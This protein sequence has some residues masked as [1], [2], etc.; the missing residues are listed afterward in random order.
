MALKRLLLSFLLF[1]PTLCAR[2]ESHPVIE[3]LRATF[4]SLAMRSKA[5]FAAHETLAGQRPVVGLRAHFGAD[6][7]GGL[8]VTFPR[9]YDGLLLAE[10]G[11]QRIVLRAIGASGAPA[12]PASGMLVYGRPYQSVDVVHVPYGG[13][14]EE[15]LLLRDERAPLVFEYEIVAT[16]GIGSVA[17]DDGG[18]RFVREGESRGAHQQ[19]LRIERPWLI[20]ANGTK[21]ETQARWSLVGE[22]AM[23]DAIRLTIDPR[24]LVFPI[25]VDPSFSATGGLAELRD[26]H[27]ATLLPDGNVLIAGGNNINIGPVESS[28]LYDPSTGIV[29]PA[30][31]L[32]FP[33]RDHSATLLRN[34]RVLVAGG[35]V[36]A[37]STATAELYDPARGTFSLTG[38][39]A[40]SR[41]RASAT[42][43]PSGEVLIVGG[44][45]GSGYAS[46]AELYD[47]VSGTFRLTGSPL[48]ERDSA[49]A[50]LLQDGRV[51]V[52]GGTWSVMTAEIYDPATGE[53]TAS[54]DL[55]TRRRRATATLLP[56]GKVLVVGGT[57]G[58]P[59]MTAELFDPA[60]GTFEETGSM[61]W[62]RFDHTATL[63][64]NG[65]VLITGGDDYNDELAT[66]E[67][68]DPATETFS[69]AD[70]L[71]SGQRTVHAAVLLQS[72]KVLLAGGRSGSFA[73]VASNELYD[74]S[75]PSSTAIASSVAPRDAATGTIL[76]NGNVLIAGGTNGTALGSAE[77]YNAATGT[78]ASTGGLAAVRAHHTA[79]LLLNGKVLVAGGE[80]SPGS[81]LSSAEVYDPATGTFAAAGTLGP[82]R[83][84]HTATLLPN[85]KVLFAGG[86]DGTPLGSA[87]LYDPASGTFAATGVLGTARLAH[88]ATLLRNGRVLIT[89][90]F[91]GVELVSAELYDPVSGTFTPT[92]DLSV[93]RVE[94]TATLLPNGKVLIVGGDG[95]EASLASAEL[96]DPESGTFS[97]AATMA[98][99][100]NDHTATLLPNGTVL[101]AGGELG[102][103]TSDEY[104]IYDPALDTFLPAR[105]LAAARAGHLAVLLRDGRTLLAGGV[106]N[107]AYVTAGE[108]FDSGLAFAAARR[109][110]IASAPLSL[111]LP[112]TLTLTGRG[113]YG[114]SEGGGATLENSAA[115]APLLHMQRIDNEESFFLIPT[116]ITSEVAWSSALATLRQGA[117]RMSIYSN[118]IPSVQQIIL[119]AHATPTISSLSPNRGL[120]SGGELVTLNGTN[121]RDVSVVLGGF[122]ATVTETTSTFARF[123]APPH[124]AG[125]V[126]VVV[127]SVTGAASTANDAYTYV[128]LPPTNVEAIATSTTSVRITWTPPA[129]ATAF[130][131]MRSS[132]GSTFAPVAEV[133][134]TAFT[135]LTVAAGR[136]YLFRVRVS[137]PSVSDASSPDLATTVLFTDHPLVPGVTRVKAVHLTEL[138]AAVAAV[139]ELAGQ[140]APSLTDPAITPG[141]TVIRAQ[142]IAELRTALNAARAALSLPAASY[143][144]PT[145]TT[146]AMVRASDLNDLRSAS[147]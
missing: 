35:M 89:G 107:D 49:N 54:G 124:A 121:L 31:N 17:L 6:V 128:A 70:P 59:Q 76:Q 141:T 56:N 41:V 13:R 96:Y 131:V 88:T 23:P 129:D 142:H 110:V 52:V 133:A 138:R 78:F 92:G 101:V 33:R 61:Q 51:L 81:P 144:Q 18:I 74:P 14:S 3:D 5:T 130:Q 63:L 120:T 27:T 147:R 29:R 50:V 30:G 34:G 104:E 21:S 146:G 105:S 109:P 44:Q 122:S 135:D 106:T 24:N 11:S 125:P 127:T 112:A 72:G 55:I 9:L 36:G 19:L 39:M 119:I 67:I 115:N 73:Y 87:R 136:S 100:R 22:R 137:A 118:A 62:A 32:R 43:L 90:G 80:V 83:S 117:Y 99:G 84:R 38:E 77:I 91:N 139:R 58:V 98:R 116:G 28:E 64:P 10:S 71:A 37:D 26:S 85:G 4:P 7:R 86:Y 126:D 48:F 113:F 123:V 8:S 103:G 65:T 60:T 75:V 93:G 132:D 102:N 94:H 57:S 40:Q 53:F 134:D 68:Y 1:S 111:A 15:L 20:D 2:A 25:V 42:L 46:V 66:A 82:A 140:S 97:P 45:S 79:T 12:M 16:E 114:D 145:P 69:A 108:V 143:A 47:P 95:A